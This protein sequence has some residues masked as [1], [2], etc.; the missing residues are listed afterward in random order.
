MYYDIHTHQAS[1]SEE[2]VRVRNLHSGFGE[3][4]HG[5]VSMGLHPWY[6]NAETLHADLRSL[7]E[8]ASQPR[9]LAIGE[10]GLDKLT[11]TPWD[12]QVSTF[13][14]QIK[15]AEEL[16]KPLIIHCVKAFQETLH[17]LRGVKVPVIFHGINNRLSL[18]EPVIRAGHYLSFGTALLQ[19]DGNIHRTVLSAP[20]DKLFLETDDMATDITVIYKL[21]GHIRQIPEKKLVLQ[22][23]RNFNKLFTIG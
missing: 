10:C 2:A 18:V 13:E 20:I 17:F 19:M 23:E 6:L 9:V 4:I 11:A 8:H 1:H 21:A 7:F 3:A 14:Q 15:I 12:L 5:Y 16:G 22:L